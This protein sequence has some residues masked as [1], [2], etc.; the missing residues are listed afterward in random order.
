MLVASE[1]GR[2]AFRTLQHC[3]LADQQ[4]E[5]ERTEFDSNRTVDSELN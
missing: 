5:A 2:Q 1:H 3:R 4:M